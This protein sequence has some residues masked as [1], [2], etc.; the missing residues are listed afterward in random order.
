MATMGFDLQPVEENKCPAWICIIKPTSPNPSHDGQQKVDPQELEALLREFADVEQDP[1]FPE[2]QNVE[3]AIDLEPGSALQMGQ[4]FR[5]APKELEELKKQLEELLSK[6][7][8]EPS[9]SPFG[10]P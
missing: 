5:L 9:S 10:A 8:I 3:H 4:V 1:K 6:G 7:L 2:P